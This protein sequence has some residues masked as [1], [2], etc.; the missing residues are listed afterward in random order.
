MPIGYHL[1]V[2]VHHKAA[3][4]GQ[5]NP[6]NTLEAIDACLTAGAPVI[7]IDATAL[8]D[9]D[10]LLVHDY[11]LE[12]ETTGLGLVA[13]CTEE[14]ARDLFVRSQH[15]PEYHVPLLSDVVHLFTARGGSSRLQIDFKSLLPFTNDEPLRRLIRIIAPLGDRVIVSSI[16]DW[17]LRK[18]R[19]LAPDLPLGL[20]IQFY[21]DW[22][23]PDETPDAHAFPQHYGAYGYYDDHPIALGRI[24]STADYLRDRCGMLLGLVPKVS[25]FYVRHQMLAQSLE[26]GFNWVDMLHAAGIQ[27]DAWTMDIGRPSAEAN[28]RPLVQSGVDMITTNTPRAMEAALESIEQTP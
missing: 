4:D 14:E 16:A 25:A 12:T 17:Q 13:A 23:P 21:L 20:D 8:A 9:G 28:L 1:P 27:L 10:Y 18:L 19:T 3:L 22:R 26:D 15:G 6:P 7:E 2:I 11:L 24:W 5:T